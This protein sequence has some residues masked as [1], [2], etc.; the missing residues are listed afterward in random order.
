MFYSF[1]VVGFGWVAVWVRVA[2]GIKINNNKSNYGRLSAVP[3]RRGRV[4]VGGSVDARVEEGFQFTCFAGT[5]VQILTQKR[6]AFHTKKKDFPPGTSSLGSSSSE[7][8]LKIQAR[9]LY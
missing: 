4:R 6:C 2:K 5:K 1:G 7:E 8:R 3:S 9:S